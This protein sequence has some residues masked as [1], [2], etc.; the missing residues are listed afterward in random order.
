MAVTSDLTHP[1]GWKAEEFSLP[2]TDGKEYSLGDLRG[3]RGLLLVFICNHCPYVLAVA[4]KL[5]Q[6]GQALLD[7]G[8]GVAAICSN[9]AR[10]HPADSFDN[11]KI[12]AQKYGFPFPYLHDETQEAARAYKAACTPDFFGFNANLELAYRGRL[13]SAG[14]DTSVKNPRR[15]L[16]EAMSMVATKGVGPKDQT[17]SMGCSIKWKQ[18]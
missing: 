15:E 6:E 14:R 8:F 1:F 17:P 16:F 7:I 5:A 3:P 11:M 2:G 9:D 18:D 13:D 12:F 10:S 4:E